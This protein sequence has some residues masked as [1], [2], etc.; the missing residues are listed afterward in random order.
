METPNPT[1]VGY[2]QLSRGYY[3]A[4]VANRETP[5]PETTRRER[6]HKQTQR[7]GRNTVAG[8]TLANHRPRRSRRPSGSMRS[9]VGLLHLAYGGGEFTVRGR[10]SVF[11]SHSCLY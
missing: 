8:W 4:T 10:L 2:D 7:D 9:V 1:F 6:P 3:L 11:P 5:S